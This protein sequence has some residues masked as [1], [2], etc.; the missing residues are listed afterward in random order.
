MARNGQ[1]TTNHNFR[2]TYIHSKWTVVE[3]FE[4][5]DDTHFLR[6]GSDELCNPKDFEGFQWGNKL[7]K[8]E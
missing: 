7:V 8:P 2:W 3:I 5:T 6:I 1:E 4:D